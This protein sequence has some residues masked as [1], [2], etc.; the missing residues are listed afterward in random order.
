MKKDPKTFDKFVDIL[1][2]EFLDTAESLKDVTEGQWKDM[3]IP[4][5]LVNKINDHIKPQ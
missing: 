2:G 1:E 5:G 4:I 3:G